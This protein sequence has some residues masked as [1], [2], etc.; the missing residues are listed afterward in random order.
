M[1]RAGHGRPAARLVHGLRRSR[2]VHLKFVSKKSWD[3]ADSTGGLGAGDK[4]LDE[5]T[6][7]AA[8]FGADGTGT[9][10][11]LRFGVGNVTAG[12]AAYA[13]A[14]QADVL[15]NARLAA[16]AA[17]ATK[18]DRP[19]WGAVSPINGEIYFTLTNNNAVVRPITDVNAVNPR[20]YDDPKGAAAT[21]QRGNPNGHVIRIGESGKSAAATS[22]S[23][24]VYLFGARSTAD[25]TNVNVSGLTAANDFSS[26]DGCWFSHASPGL[27]WLETDDGAYTDVTNCMLLAALPGKVGDG[28][29][30]TITS[31]DGA[32]TKAVD[33]YVGKAPGDAALRRFLVGPRQCEITGVAE[34]PDGRALFVNIQHPGE[35]TVPDFADAASFG[36]H[37]P[38]GG[39][40]RPRSATIV[41]T[42]DDG[43]VVGVAG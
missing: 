5:G 35:E 42:R 24:D 25:A 27:L 40:A 11:E 39:T 10:L 37:W 32:T 41:I 34:A 12:N 3:P 36:S 13:F 16:D 18:M 4:Y 20:F 9:W 43:G 30:K 31:T 23:W 21:P 2:R 33:T 19:E 15:V 6:L 17:G 38:D 22:F 28:G 7:Y 26:P 14:D 8:K 1:A 29:K